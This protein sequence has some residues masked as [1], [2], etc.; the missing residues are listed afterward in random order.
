MFVCV[1]IPAGFVEAVAIDVIAVE[2]CDVEVI[3]EL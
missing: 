2:A 3:P 1:I